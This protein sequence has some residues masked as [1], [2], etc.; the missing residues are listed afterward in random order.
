[1][2]KIGLLLCLLSW[3]FVLNM[4]GQS[5]TKDDIKLDYKKSYWAGKIVVNRIE[6]K[7]LVTVKITLLDETNKNARK[8]YTLRRGQTWTGDI[9]CTFVGSKSEDGKT[10]VV[11]YKTNGIEHR[12]IRLKHQRQKF[13]RATL[14]KGGSPNMYQIQRTLRPQQKK[15]QRSRMKSRTTSSN[16]TRTSIHCSRTTR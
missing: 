6:N 13:R 2:R 9:T 12:Q 16:L 3:C 4:F 7:S 14:I 11:L 1:M 10:R 5:Y 8:E 15:Q